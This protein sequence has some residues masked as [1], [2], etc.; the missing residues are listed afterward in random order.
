MHADRHRNR[1][2]IH[3]VIKQKLDLH[4]HNSMATKRKK[5]YKSIM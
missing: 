4:K 5:T 2:E 3:T 1:L